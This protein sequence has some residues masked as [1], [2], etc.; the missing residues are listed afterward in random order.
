[1]NNKENYR[2]LLKLHFE[3]R[4]L[5]N[6]QYSLRAFAGDLDLPVST[7]SHIMNG[8][9]SLQYNKALEIS[10]RLNLTLLEKNSFVDQ[11]Y[12]E[13]APPEY[14]LI[15]NN[16]RDI[17]NEPLHFVLLN[18]I[19]TKNFKSD[20][21]WIAEQLNTTES[22]INKILKRLIEA[23][24]IE[25]TQG[26]IRRLKESLMI[27]PGK[28]VEEQKNFH[29]RILQQ[30]VN[31]L[32]HYPREKRYLTCTTLAINKKDLPKAM[33]ELAKARENI[34]KLLESQNK[35]EIYHLEL[36]LFPSI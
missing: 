18:F 35:E 14:S 27:P 8:K 31:A 4:C 19:N 13:S 3:K 5:K 25:C 6:D 29:K 2:Q 30:A 34:S 23:K 28:Y 36:G 24:L 21:T 32:D 17:L 12:L 26:K 15:E 7:L 22:N 1:M 10:E 20:T 9:R 11:V 33:K 16:D